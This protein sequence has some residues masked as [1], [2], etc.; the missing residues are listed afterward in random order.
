MLFR[1][2]FDSRDFAIFQLADFLEKSDLTELTPASRF[3]AE[4]LIPIIRFLSQC[5]QTATITSA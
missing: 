1:N 5:K 4:V 3:T 2:P